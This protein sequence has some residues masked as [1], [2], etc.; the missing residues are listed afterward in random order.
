MAEDMGVAALHVAQAVEFIAEEQGGAD[1]HES[2]NGP[3]SQGAPQDEAAREALGKPPK[4]GSVFAG[5]TQWGDRCFSSREES[6]LGSSGLGGGDFFG[7][8]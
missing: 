4:P 1:V 7:G 2:Q 5:A 8:G 3:H 6:T